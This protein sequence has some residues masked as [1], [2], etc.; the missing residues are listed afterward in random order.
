[1]QV[2][3]ILMEK[4]DW[5][6]V[7]EEIMAGY[8]WKNIITLLWMNK[9]KIPPKYWIRFLY[10]IALA[11]FTTPMRI[12]Q[13]I[14]AQKISKKTEIT[15]DP[16]FIIGNYRTG[17][18]YLITM[19]SKD[20]SRGYVSNLLGYTFS[21]FLAIPKLS[22]HI[23][24]ASL[25]EYRPMDNV[26]MGA[27][28][29]TEEEYCLG[30]FSKYAYYH[31]MVFPQSFRKMAKYHSFDGLPKDAAKWQKQYHYLLKILTHIYGGRQLF[32]K[33]PVSAFRIKYLLEKYPN[34]KFIFTYRNPYTLYASNLNYY[35][36]V[37][38]FYTL[39]HFTEDML[40]EEI[41]DH[42][43]EMIHK[44]DEGKKLIPEGNYLEIKYE[45]FIKS[46]MPFMEKIYSQFKLDGWDEARPA[47]QAHYD[48]QAE[49]KTNNFRIAD[50]VIRTVNEK[51][52]FIV[53]KQGYDILSPN[54]EIVRTS[55][56]I[57]IEE[58]S[59]NKQKNLTQTQVP[60]I[61]DKSK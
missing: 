3:V 26:K 12:I 4:P 11:T 24:D 31:G 47:F 27:D 61:S 38:P 9:F 44:L 42:Y 60:I 6:V 18:T 57:A 10:A 45:D 23:I 32:L 34:A 28:E 35:K 16:V 17:T 52:D 59:D 54:K 48:A 51:W 20:K 30:T 22:R 53:K 49:Y 5:L 21:F 29:P 36:K 46:P 50:E 13:R 25:P 33:N 14:K 56:E 41:L 7:S 19:L 15:K 40:K 37:V 55:Q 8:T 1:M 39:Q 43:S 2:V 58:N